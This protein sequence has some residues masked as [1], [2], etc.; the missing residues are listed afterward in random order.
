MIEA[1]TKLSKPLKSL[2]KPVSMASLAVFRI[3]FGLMMFVASVRFV[4][5]SWVDSLYLQPTYFFTWPG[6]SFIRPLPEPFMTA[7]V[8]VTGLAALGIALGLGYRYCCL[9]FFLGFTYQEL[10][11]QTNYLNHYYLISMLSFGMIWLPLHGRYAL[12]GLWRNPLR[13]H[14][15]Q[16]VLW[17]FRVQIALVYLG[18]A[19][20]KLNAD[21]L[22][23]AQPLAIW[24][25]ALSEELPIPELW[26]SSLVHYAGSWGTVL[27]E[28]AI[29]PCLLWSKTRLMA[30]VALIVFHLF[31]SW[32]FPIGVFPFLMILATTLYFAPDWP[33]RLKSQWV[34]ERLTEGGLKPTD[35]A[36]KRAWQPALGV[37]AGVFLVA[38]ILIPLRHYWMEG[39]VLWNE[40]GARFGWRVM[41]K[42]KTGHVRFQ[43]IRGEQSVWVAPQ[44]WLTARQEKMMSTRPEMI[45]QFALHL[46]KQHANGAAV[47]QVKV[48]SWAA[49]NGRPAQRLVRADVDLT[50]NFDSVSEWIVPLQPQ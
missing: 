42:E 38:Q 4:C 22:L 8:L 16:A 31:T 50:Q 24:L 37:A 5:N 30:W 20:S 11:D 27:F 17:A 45:R 2:N 44:E 28:L 48:D 12:D 26:Q 35:D 1:R 32:L 41:L 23:E 40:Q 18:A 34:A 33:E 43:V 39:N 9:L 47:I 25:T 15:P 3:G 49:L 7:L 29:V 10:I 21:W 19:L 36:I 14:L 46:K 13:T 6:F